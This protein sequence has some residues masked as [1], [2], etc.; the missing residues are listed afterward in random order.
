ME[1]L[2]T[3]PQTGNFGDIATKINDN[4]NKMNVAVETVKS[5][6][7]AEKGYYSTVGSL[8]AAYPSPKPGDV[9]YVADP[10]S[11]TGYYIYD[12][13]NSAWHATTVEAPAVTVAINNYTPNGGSTKTAQQIDDEKLAKAAVVQV[14]GTS[15]ADVM[16][17]KAVTDELVQLAGDVTKIANIK[18]T[19]PED[20]YASKLFVSKVSAITYFLDKRVYF[21]ANE[22]FNIGLYLSKTEGVSLQFLT[23]SN[24]IVSV[25]HTQTI[26]GSLGVVRVQKSSISY[27]FSTLIDKIYVAIKSAVS[28]SEAG[29]YNDMPSN[30]NTFY[31]ANNGDTL[32]AAGVELGLWIEFGNVGLYERLNR[33]EI[34]NGGFRDLQ[35]IVSK[36]GKVSLPEK[37]YPIYEPLLVPSGTSI[38]GVYGKTKII[39]KFAGSVGGLI[40]LT[41]KERIGISNI[42]FDGEEA[43]T[44]SAMTALEVKSLTGFGTR[45]CIEISTYC[46]NIELSNLV[47]KNFSRQ[48]LSIANTLNPLENP[49]APDISLSKITLQNNYIGLYFAP[50][51]E[52]IRFSN[53]Q[54]SYNKIGMW[55]EGG[56][57]MGSVCQFNSNGCGIVICGTSNNNDTHGS[58]GNST[59]NHNKSFSI[60]NLDVNNGFTFNG[61]HVFEGEIYLENSRGVLL[62]GGIIDAPINVITN[63]GVN[64]IHGNIFFKG[65]GGGTIAGDTSM[66][67]LKNNRFADNSSS[68]IINN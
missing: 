14:K 53:I 8:S 17:Q 46:K 39:Q 34:I 11:S 4:F 61:C 31:Y 43:V 41:E 57:N 59:I 19:I 27:D 40:L 9:G 7:V 52:F 23:I 44:Q 42:I 16:S 36:G 20:T 18:P 13:V 1:S 49:H 29:S 62:Q 51:A 30:T 10:A 12:V 47:I 55:L 33:L 24:N 48:A 63:K 65:Y 56:N 3:I 25:I 54:A 37:E 5:N 50:R 64:M 35:D 6:Y 45:R 15:L 58:I 22:D 21:Y 28:G 38:T 32:T 26:S 68:V 67:D 60:F 66:L 2:N